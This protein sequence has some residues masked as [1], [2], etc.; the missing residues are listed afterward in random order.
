MRKEFSEI[1]WETPEL[2][3][4]LLSYLD[5]TSIKQLAEFHKVTRRILRNTVTW[6]KL[7]KRIFPEDQIT[8]NWTQFVSG[9]DETA[10]LAEKAIICERFPIL[11]PRTGS[12]L[13]MTPIVNVSCSRSTECHLGGYCSWRTSRLPWA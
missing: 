7:L 9:I 8:H 2:V 4:K 3:D 13:V 1:F 11:D 10:E 6:N 12:I 5:L